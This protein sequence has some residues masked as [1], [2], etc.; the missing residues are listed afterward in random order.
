MPTRRIILTGAPGVGKTAVLAA[1]GLD[2]VGEPARE[3]LAEH[4]GADFPFE[5]FVARLLDRSIRKWEA[6]AGGTVVYDRGV[7]DCAA[8]AR[9]FGVDAAAADAAALR[10]CY[11]PEVLV[12]EP[13]E[14]IY[15]TDARR[16][17]T[18]EMTVDFHAAI[19]EAFT[20]AGYT[21]VPVPRAPIAVRAAF[22]EEFVAA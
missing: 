12:L 22:V 1:T 9:Y 14:A 2:H 17:M 6:A 4:P 19:E 18:F 7:P 11:H 5:E 16:T 3:I 15:T 13:W 21:F 8:Y 10:Y 20:A